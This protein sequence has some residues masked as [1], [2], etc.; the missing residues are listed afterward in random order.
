MVY[1]VVFGINVIVLGEM[2]IVNMV[3]V[4]CLMVWLC[5]LLVV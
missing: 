5:D 1:Y 2:G 3:F 4:V